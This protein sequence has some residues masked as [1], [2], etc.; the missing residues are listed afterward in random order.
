MT[1]YVYKIQIILNLKKC[2]NLYWKL[3]FKSLQ[4]NL[5]IYIKIYITLFHFN[6]NCKVVTIYGQVKRQKT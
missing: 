5:L 4:K 3:N 6:H 2:K 1:L